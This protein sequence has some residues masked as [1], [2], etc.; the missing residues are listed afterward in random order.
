M[1]DRLH[2]HLF[3]TPAMAQK[4]IGGKLS[5]RCSLSIGL[6]RPEIRPEERKLKNNKNKI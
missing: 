4:W 5:T 3:V 2:G 1:S 6:T